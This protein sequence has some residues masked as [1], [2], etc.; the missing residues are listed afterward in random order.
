MP[1]HLGLAD[2]A[3]GV[4]FIERVAGHDPSVRGDQV[5]DAA[6][7][8]GK[9]GE[10]L[11]EVVEVDDPDHRPGK[12]AARPCDGAAQQQARLAGQQAVQRQRELQPALRMGAQAGEPVPPGEVHAA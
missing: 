7:V 2:V 4:A 8:E 11:A 12:R 9:T 1:E 3:A 5:D 6:L 10:E